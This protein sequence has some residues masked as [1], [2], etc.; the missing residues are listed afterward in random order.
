MDYYYITFKALIKNFSRPMNEKSDQFGLS[1]EF[2]AM[3]ERKKN[4]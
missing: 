3:V 1:V 4:N 2:C